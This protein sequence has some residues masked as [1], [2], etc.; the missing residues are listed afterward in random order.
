MEDINLR[1]MLVNED[2]IISDSDKKHIDNYKNLIA[3]FENAIAVSTK[4]GKADYESLLKSCMKCIRFLDTV[5]FS[6]DREMIAAKT[7][8]ATIMSIIELTEKKEED[9][10]KKKEA[11]QSISQSLDL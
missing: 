7:R 10:G 11:D 5:V 3:Y 2:N 4:E 6:Y 1:P 9:A 8:N